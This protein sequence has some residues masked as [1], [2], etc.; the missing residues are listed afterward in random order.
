M[1]RFNIAA[2]Y[3]QFL[4]GMGGL[5]AI[6]PLSN[7]A[8]S[9]PFIPTGGFGGSSGPMISPGGFGGAST[10]ASTGWAQPAQGPTMDWRNGQSG[11]VGWGGSSGRDYSQGMSSRDWAISNAQKAIE[12]YSQG[13]GQSQMTGGGAV[14]SSGNA[15][16][17]EANADIQAAAAKI[18]V[19]ANLLKTII[20]RESS[21]NWADQSQPKFIQARNEW[22]HGYVGMFRPAVEANG[23]DFDALTGN[24]AL[25]IEALAAQLK[26]LANDYGGWDNAIKVHFMGPAALNDMNLMDGT[27]AGALS[28]G[29]YYNAAKSRWNQLDQLSGNSVGAGAG[30]DMGVGGSTNVI[31]DLQ[32]YVGRTPYKWGFEDT[33]GWDCSGL[34]TWLDQKYGNGTIPRTSQQQHA[35]A[36]ASGTLFYDD[37]QLK[38]G[39]LLFFA[40]GGPGGGA[41]H[42]GIYAGNGKMIHAANPSVGTIVSD[43]ASYKQNYQ[44]MGASHAPWSGGASG[45]AV[46]GIPTGG[47]GGTNYGYQWWRQ[48]P[49]G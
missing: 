37:A 48:M 34:V 3:G 6:N 27:H 5:D 15:A 16:L 44:F 4:P 33:A 19:P 39:D 45:G 8:A 21:G 22:I 10:P 11:A 32:Q 26:R 47:G 9:Q 29:Q 30:L 49:G 1:D 14:G 43:L 31:A 35:Q 42:V 25:Q 7:T 46:P 40:T 41:S 2:A 24:R 17:D 12:K 36:Q 23:Y 18:G 28:V 20:E 13:I 38:A